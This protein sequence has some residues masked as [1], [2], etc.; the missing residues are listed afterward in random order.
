MRMQW[1]ALAGLVACGPALAGQLDELQ[2]KCSQEQ[3][4]LLRDRN[5]TPSC[6]MVKAMLGAGSS[7]EGG[8]AYIQQAPPAAD[9][10]PQRVYDASS[11]RWCW[12][13]PN[14]APMQCD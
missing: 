14:G 13:Y 10:S 2:R 8:R 6:D 1:I 3:R 9:A 4:S 5:G 11:R 12:V 7:S